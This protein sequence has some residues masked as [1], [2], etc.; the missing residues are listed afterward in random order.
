MEGG[1]NEYKGALWVI[2]HDLD[3]LSQINI[4]QNFKVSEQTLQMTTYLPSTPKQ[5]YQELLESHKT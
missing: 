3:F 5:Y 4:S 2:S 1:I